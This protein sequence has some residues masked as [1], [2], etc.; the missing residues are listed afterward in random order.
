MIHKLKYI[1]AV[2]IL[3]TSCKKQ[4][5]INT[6][7][8]N[9]VTLAESKLLPAVEVNLSNSL[10]IGNGVVGGLSDDLETYVHQTVVREDPDQYGATGDDFY[11]QTNW[12]TFYI[13]L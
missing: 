11:I 10:S 5:D 12:L 4:L 2:I 9:P 6:D 3:M 8:N 7:P 13:S 1:A